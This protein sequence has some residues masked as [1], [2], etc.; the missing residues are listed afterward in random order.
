MGEL[1]EESFIYAK[2]HTRHLQTQERGFWNIPSFLHWATSTPT[3]TPTPTPTSSSFTSKPGSPECNLRGWLHLSSSSSTT[4]VCF[5]DYFGPTCSHDIF[6]DLAFLPPPHWVEGMGANN[7]RWD[8]F[9]HRYQ[10][11]VDVFWPETDRDAAHLLDRLETCRSS[12]QDDVIAQEYPMNGFGSNL[13]FFTLPLARVLD[14]C[15]AFSGIRPQNKAGMAYPYADETMCRARGRSP[16]LSCFLDLETDKCRLP[17]GWQW[18]TMGIEK[19]MY[20][21][22]HP[23]LEGVTLVRRHN[24]G[25]MDPHRVPARYQVGGKG[26][27]W[28]QTILIDQVWRL[29]PDVEA[30]LDDLE[31]QRR[32]VFGDPGLDADDGNAIG[33]HIRHGDSCMDILR[34]RHCYGLEEY[35]QGA[36]ELRRRYGVHTIMLATDSGAV[37][38]R[39]RKEYG[40]EGSGWVFVL[41][42][43]EGRGVWDELGKAFVIHQDIEFRLQGSG[44]NRTR[45]AYAVLG[46]LRMLGKARYIVGSFTSNLARIALSLASARSGRLVPYVGVDVPWCFHWGLGWPHPQHAFAP[47]FY[48]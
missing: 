13:Q 8:V 26:V 4:C 25:S 28:F 35:M 19:D 23:V 21:L 45:E 18:P 14:E 47:H 44:V 32:I 41:Q 31:R 2:Q 33:I 30:E 36:E 7:E 34:Y 48:C 39:A 38:D 22:D 16:D 27:F 37:V 43:M 5:S 24:E 10:H 20:A 42:R 29:H 6:R 40:R 15:V 46:D 1:E 12:C 11:G 9:D 3:S 17:P